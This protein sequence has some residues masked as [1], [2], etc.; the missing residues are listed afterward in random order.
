MT[1][2]PGIIIDGQPAEWKTGARGLDPE[3][4]TLAM[5]HGSGGS[6]DSWPDQIHVLD[7]RI[8]VAAL[9]L[10]GH[11]LSQGPLKPSVKEASEWVC[12]VLEAWDLPRP[13]VLAGHS[14]GG[15]VTIE[16]GLTRPDLIGG[17]VLVG[18]GAHLPVN[19]ALIEK[20]E[21]DFPSA[22]AL[23]MKWAFA[24]ST[25]PALVQATLEDVLKVPPAVLINDFKACDAFDRRADL[26]AV[27]R[28]TL[29]VCGQNDKLTPPSLSEFILEKISGACLEIIEEAGHQVMIEQPEKFNRAVLNFIEEIK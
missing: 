11:G 7:D 23:I 15:A 22:A 14:L 9:E 5:I 16:T 28:P 29:I 1:V 18:T 8:N 25:D 12:R 21:N 3:R 6:K 27:S 10:P 26:E 2:E 24:K 17:L 20:L 19:P 13:P 4:P